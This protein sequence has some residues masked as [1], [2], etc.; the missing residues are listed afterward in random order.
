MVEPK[1]RTHSQDWAGRN[2]PFYVM[3]RGAISLIVRLGL[4][5]A[6]VEGAEHVPPSG[7]A[8]LM[9][10]HESNLDPLLIAFRLVRPVN[11]PGK[12]ELFRIP[13][14]KHL[15]LA[16]GCYPVNRDE[17]DA[18]SL[19]RSLT[20]LRQGRLLAVFPE[21]TRSRDGEIGPFGPTLIRLAIREQA[22]IIP[23][24]V[25]GSA[26]ILRPGGVWPRL[27]ARV[28]VRYGRPL[29]LSEYHGRRLTEEEIATATSEIRRRVIELRETRPA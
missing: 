24:A 7:A 4:V 9:S 1:A 14:L 19:R 3:V 16:L 5:R 22:P 17:A 2:R 21:G 8:V 25:E 26:G 12:L 28:T 15:I 27:G 20:V 10:N 29:V 18:G 13:V 11:I 23:V 6:R